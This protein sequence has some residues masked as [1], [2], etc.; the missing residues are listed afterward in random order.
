MVPGPASETGEDM[1][2]LQLHGG[3]AVI[4][5]VLAALGKLEGLS[6]RGA[7]RVHPPRLRGTAGSISR[8]SRGSATSSRR[9]RRRSGARPLRSSAACSATGPRAG[10]KG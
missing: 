10:G 5:A 2:E 1:A 4:A 3:R 6:P 9:R 8:K 7:R